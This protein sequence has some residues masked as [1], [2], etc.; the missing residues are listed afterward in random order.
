M[1]T[2]ASPAI[3]TILIAAVSILLGFGVHWSAGVIG[4]LVAVV[5][6]WLNGRSND[7]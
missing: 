3:V 4:L 2:S 1:S 5:Y 7:V 6:W